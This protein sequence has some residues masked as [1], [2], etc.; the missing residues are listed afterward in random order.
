MGTT[1][2]PGSINSGPGMCVYDG[3]VGQCDRI[4]Y[5]RLNAVLPALGKMDPGRLSC[6]KHRGYLKTS[7]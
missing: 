5:R 3:V 6:G 7:S 1:G 2:I 4:E